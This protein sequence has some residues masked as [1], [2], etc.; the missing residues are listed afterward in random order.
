M[1]GKGKRRLIDSECRKGNAYM[2]KPVKGEFKV[3]KPQ[4]LSQPC[5]LEALVLGIQLRRYGF[6]Y[7]LYLASL[8]RIRYILGHIHLIHVHNSSLQIAGPQEVVAVYKGL[9][10]IRHTAYQKIPVKGVRKLIMQIIGHRGKGFHTGRNGFQCRLA[11]PTC[12]AKLLKIKGI[13]GYFLQKANGK[14]GNV[15][16]LKP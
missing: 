9:H 5:V 12:P 6:V 2:S 4:A 7:H 14:G 15:G 10:N 1:G 13:Q 11:Y 3:G 16:Y 8:K